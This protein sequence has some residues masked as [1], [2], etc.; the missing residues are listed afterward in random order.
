MIK[1]IGPKMAEDMVR[2]RSMKQIFTPRQE[3]LLTGKKRIT[4]ANHSKKLDSLQSRL[5]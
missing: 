5:L 3:E 2:R 4:P 1:G